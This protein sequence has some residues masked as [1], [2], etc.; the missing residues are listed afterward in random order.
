MNY[1]AAGLYDH[2]ATLLDALGE[3]PGAVAANLRNDGV[4]GMRGSALAHPVCRWLIRLVPDLGVVL[5]L[6]TVHVFRPG[7]GSSVHGV[8]V[9]MPAPVQA[10]VDR[11]DDGQ[12]PELEIWLGPPLASAGEVN[13]VRFVPQQLPNPMSLADTMLLPCIPVRPS[14]VIVDSEVVGHRAGLAGEY[15]PSRDV[16]RLE[17][18]VASHRHLAVDE[19]RPAG[20]A[21][22][23]AAGVR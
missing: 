20:G 6:D 18:P 17:R 15:V 10:F 7:R 19:L 3:D 21:D 12:Y 23:T 13:P 2:I 5:G 8:T 16:F 22:S 1:P 4:R 14:A 9:P 11:F